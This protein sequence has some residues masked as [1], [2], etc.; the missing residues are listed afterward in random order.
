[1]KRLVGLTIRHQ[2]RALKGQSGSAKIQLIFMIL[3]FAAPVVLSYIWYFFVHPVGHKNYGTLL[4]V[5]PLPEVH[6]KDESGK[7]T[8]LA[9]FKGKWL[10]IA[11]DSADCN[12]ACETK[13]Y[14]LR[15]VR[16]ALGH[17]DDRV[18]RVLLIEGEANVRS[19]ITQ[20][21][22]GTHWFHLSDKQ[23]SDAL[24]SE[25]GEPKD[26]IW[27]VDPLGNVVMRYPANPELKG[28]LKDMERLL[29]ASQIG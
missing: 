24:S 20:Q 15:Q 4:D 12:Q 23:L 17:D 9:T 28:I 13:L 7:E 1:M 29:K 22:Q 5:H 6:L 10:L 16:A 21:Y 2:G 18:E 26:H 19:D 25:K 11:E 14:A 3:V 8:S 27:V